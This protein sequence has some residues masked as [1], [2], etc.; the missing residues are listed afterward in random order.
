MN[1]LVRGAL[2]P[3]DALR[4][5]WRATSHASI[6]LHPDD[7]YHPSVDAVLEALPL[8]DAVLTACEELGYARAD[9]GCGIGEAID[10]LGCLFTALD[11]PVPAQALR[12]L[13]LGWVDGQAA[14]P[15]MACVDAGSGLH[16]AEY[17]TVRLQE[18]YGAA[19]RAGVL[20][21]ENHVLVF[22]DAG[23]ENLPFWD[24]VA[25]S[26][27]MGAA[28]SSAF[29]EGHPVAALGGG[30]YVALVERSASTPPALGEL[31]GLIDST[32]STMGISATLRRPPRVWT[33]ELPPTH[34]DAATLVASR[35]R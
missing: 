2:P 10:D 1:L 17:F 7:W 22:V 5:Q 30:A 23:L 32:A 14:V 35:Q 31:R 20:A 11:H 3:R 26:A 9:A 34:A 25:R 27:G 6:W 4:E 8:G 28:L 21:R 16:T 33:E 24:R 12:S 29:G 18:T 19:A 13:T 15:P